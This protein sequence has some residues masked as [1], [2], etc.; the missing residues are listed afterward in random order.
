MTSDKTQNKTV[1]KLTKN[2]LIVGIGLLILL[3]ALINGYTKPHNCEEAKA[4]LKSQDDLRSKAL[5]DGNQ[6]LFGAGTEKF[7]ELSRKKD[8]LCK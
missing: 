1:F 2:R 4:M 8:E 6:G 5:R 7:E 3:A